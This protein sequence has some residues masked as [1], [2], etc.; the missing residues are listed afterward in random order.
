MDK[1]K[2]QEIH[3]NSEMIAFQIAGILSK[4]NDRYIDESLV[5]QAVKSCVKNEDLIDEIY[6]ATI[7]LLEDKYGILFDVDKKVDI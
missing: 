4:N 5:F 2:K 6:R 7:Q 1:E 3:I